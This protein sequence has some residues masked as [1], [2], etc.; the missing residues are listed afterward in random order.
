[1]S[2]TALD[3][4]KEELRKLNA[5]YIPKVGW[6]FNMKV[7]M[8]I[9]ENAAKDP[10][11]LRNYIVQELDKGKMILNNAIDEKIRKIGEV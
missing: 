4:L 6:H 1:M 7:G 9:P 5:Q 11:T 3:H 8:L 2:K 10:V